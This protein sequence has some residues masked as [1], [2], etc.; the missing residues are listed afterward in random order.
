MENESQR[1]KKIRQTLNLSQGDFGDNLGLSAAMVSKYESGERQITERTRISICK[2][3]N[4]SYSYLT[5]GVMPMFDN[6]PNVLMNDLSDKYNLD[7]FDKSLVEEYLKL[8]PDS[9][10]KI[11]EYLHS[12]ISRF[13]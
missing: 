3:Y 9:R 11:K 7:E 13:I 5:G 8:S 4:I 6:F 2:V 10:A 1:L 12:V